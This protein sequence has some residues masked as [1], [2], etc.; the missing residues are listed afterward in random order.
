MRLAYETFRIS[1]G[2]GGNIF[3]RDYDH[4]GKLAEPCWF[5]HLWHLCYMFQ[6]PIKLAIKYEVPLMRERD[7][8]LMDAFIE[9][10]IWQIDQLERLNIVRR[11]KKVFSK[12]DILESDG[13]TVLSS[14]MD[15]SEGTST[16]TFPK[17][18]P[19]RKDLELWQSALYHLTSTT[20]T[21]MRPLGRYIN[22]PHKTSGWY[23]SLD[24]QYLY[25]R[26]KNGLFDA[27]RKSPDARSSRIS[28]YRPCANSYSPPLILPYAR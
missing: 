26:C 27:F 24:R 18:K 20:L 23:Q 28:K 25:R 22:P 6:S 21:L 19:R 5:T 12:S 11:Y 15:N 9:T 14:M 3:E 1:V 17:E 4:L 13:Q 7:T 2:L 8:S 16:W 10:G